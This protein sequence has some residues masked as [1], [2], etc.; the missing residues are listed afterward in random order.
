[1][2]YGCTERT[3]PKDWFEAFS[4]VEKI[5]EKADGGNYITGK[6]VVFL[7][8][9]PWMDTPKSDFKS[10]LDYFWNSWGSSRKDLLFIVCGSATSWIIN[11][12]IKDT[13]GFYNRVTRQIHLMPFCLDECE[14]LLE[15]NGVNMPRKQIIESYMVFGGIPYYLN[16]LKPSLSLAQNIDSLFFHENSPLKFEF[17]QLFAALF[18]NSDHYIEIIN[19]L[20]KRKNGASRNDLLG[21]KTLVK[22]KEL[23]KCLQELEQCGFIRKYQSISR[24]SESVYQLIDSLTLFH[25]T[26]IDG[27]KSDSWL[28]FINSPSYY[29]WCGLAFERVCLMHTKQI[30]KALG[31][32]GISSNDY[33]WRSTG[34]DSGAQIDLLIDRKDNVINLCEMKFCNDEFVIDS[35]Y[36][37]ELMQKINAFKSETKTRKALLPTM[38]TMFGIKDN[39]HSKAIICNITGDD[40][41]C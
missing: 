6:K 26:F 3:I 22:G 24:K 13:G 15:S 23:T 19:V 18:R 21:Q 40:L 16:Y 33:S 27:K 30:K 17:N 12:I 14:K 11:N 37:K 1:M 32:N 35:Q 4:R 9:L 38:V 34:A 25:L 28:D 2:K 39:I 29:A 10:A 31:I 20:A 36:E 7:D 41:F 5:L 8:E